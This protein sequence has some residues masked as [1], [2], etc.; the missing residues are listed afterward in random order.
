MLMKN[1]NL[2]L[3]GTLACFLFG[4]T[5]CLKTRAQLREESNDQSRPI[6]VE[7]AQDVKPNEA[8]AVDELRAEITHLVGRVEDLERAEKDRSV[9]GS[10]ESKEELK[11]VEEQ[12]RQLDESYQ[13]LSEELKKLE[14]APV[15]A[16]PVDLFKKAKNQFSSQ[17]YELAAE[18]FGNYIKIPKAKNLQ[19]ALFLRGESYY[20]LKQY[21][22]AI[23]EY[24]KISEKYSHSPH[25]AE[26]LYKIG[27]SFEALGMKE[28]AKG[29]YQE[30]V[31]KFP[32]SEE[33]K[34]SRK[35]AK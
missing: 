23:V 16:D 29:F 9:K 10:A 7:P 1:R 4:A 13:T 5:G 11:K 20:H 6:A 33:A 19:D 21:K 3:T 2:I 34:K 14:K 25:M 17:E 32:K 27:L 15:V 35:K 22:K 31:E 18:T 8:Y 12:I 24:S 26:T 30:L 28:D